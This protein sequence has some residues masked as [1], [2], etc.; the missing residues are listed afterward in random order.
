MPKLISPPHRLA[1]IPT[2]VVIPSVSCAAVLQGLAGTIIVEVPSAD[3]LARP[4][5]ELAGCSATP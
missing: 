1:G 2:Q 4:V 5:D 3:G